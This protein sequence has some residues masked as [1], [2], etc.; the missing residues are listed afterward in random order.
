MSTEGH[1]DFAF[2]S[3]PGLPEHLPRDEQMLW[4]GRP[5]WWALTKQALGFWW[6]TVY[7]A[8]LGLWRF[9]TISDQLPLTEALLGLV[10][11]AVFWAVVALV[12]VVI[13]RV[14]A[15][16]TVYTV[17]NRRVVMRIGAA[18]TITLNV[19]HSQIANAEA[20]IRK[21]GTGTIAFETLG[22][23]RINYVVAWPHVKPWHFKTR[24]ALRCIPDAKHV[25]ALIAEHAQARLAE[26]KLEKVAAGD[27]V[28]AE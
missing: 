22:K 12:L 20:A 3:I 6:V 23:T 24:L 4:Q 27:P 8:L 26:P 14:Q 1:D 18:L 10:P 16:A 5:E 25:A 21:D 11:L 9:A 2:E 7:F 19:P 15:R 28:P 17:T 13:G